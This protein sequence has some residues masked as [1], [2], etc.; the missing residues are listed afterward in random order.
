MCPVGEFTRFGRLDFELMLLRRMADHQPALVEDKVR[1]LGLT[2]ADVRIAN[3]R[4]QAMIR[5]RTFPADNRR[6]RLVL[7]NP[8]TVYEREFGDL[9]SEVTQWEMQLWPDYW[10]ETIAIPG[11]CPVLQGWLVRAPGE[12]PPPEVRTVAD[13]RPWGCVVAEVERWF[14]P[15]RHAEDNT[16]S[17]W[18]MVFAASEQ[19][20]KRHYLAKFS[21]GLLQ[22]VECLPGWGGAGGGPTP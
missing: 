9:R 16:P 20:G 7:G 11:G 6:Y 22:A 19:T 17:R 10:F 13:L 3:R 1:G 2:R 4:W 8:V 18:S 21:W 15:V 12:A 5:S 14:G